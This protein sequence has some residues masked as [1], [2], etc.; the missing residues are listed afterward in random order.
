MQA[1]EN[2]W[3]IITNIIIIICIDI[4]WTF[5]I[6]PAPRIYICWNMF[7]VY[8]KLY[9]TGQPVFLFAKSQIFAF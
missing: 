8:L 9:S 6:A 2:E 5:L 4:E 3:M 1:G 7:V